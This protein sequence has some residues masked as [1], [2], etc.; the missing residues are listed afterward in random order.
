MTGC[1]R[2]SG[3]AGAVDRRN[4]GR[5]R[6]RD[7]CLLVPSVYANLVGFLLV[8]AGASNVVP[9]LFSVAGRT[10]AMPPSLAVTAVT[11]LGYLGILVGPALIGFVAHLTDLRMAFYLLKQIAGWSESK[12]VG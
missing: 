5:G 1:A 9:V 10:R 3:T 7:G 2:S 6:I 12:G 8:G 11:T 4:P